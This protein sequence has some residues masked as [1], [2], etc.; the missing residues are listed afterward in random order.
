MF[1][2]PGEGWWQTVWWALPQEGWGCQELLLN[3]IILIYTSIGYVAV[4]C[5]VAVRVAGLATQ[6]IVSRDGAVTGENFH[7]T[8]H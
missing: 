8:K 4:L 2:K 3:E 1:W 7:A 6:L 5:Y